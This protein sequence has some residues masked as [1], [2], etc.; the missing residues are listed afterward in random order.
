[1]WK[2][3]L[4]RFIILIPQLIA[5]SLLIFI[6]AEIMPGDALFGTFIED[7]TMDHATIHQMMLDAGFFDPWYVNYARWMG[8]MFQGDFGS[9]LIHRRPVTEMIGE[10]MGNTLLLS[11]VS[12][13]IIYSFAIPLGIIAGRWFGKWPEKV[14][15]V[16]NFLQLA[17]PTVVF[18]IVLQWT[19]AITLGVLPLRGSVDIVV[20]SGGDPFAI[21]ISRIRHAI[22]PA[23]SLS[24]LAGVGVIQLL[25]NE[26]NDYKN[27]D[28]TTLAISKGVPLNHVYTKHIFRNSILPIAASSGGIIVG[29]FSGAVIIE[30]IFTFPG[31]GQLFVNSIGQRD[32]PVANFLIIFYAT[33][34]V[35][36]F[37]ISDIMLTVF[38]PRIR[39]K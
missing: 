3:T 19:F 22:L 24:L 2:T 6:L 32:W 17:F 33:L 4:R 37:L 7:P 21:F 36:G 28:F 8:N 12:V 39:I 16:Y 25:A 20:V 34:S 15:S 13:L 29:L 23:L 18:A 31:M 30:T 9:S 1:M 27:M 26:I 11:T 5:L 35:I 10:R 38:D 14:I